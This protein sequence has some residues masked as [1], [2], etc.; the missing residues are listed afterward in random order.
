MAATFVGHPVLEECE[1]RDGEW[2]AAAAPAS[3]DSASVDDGSAS[4]LLCVLLGS[5]AQ[6]V[7][8]HTPLFGATQSLR[9]DRV[10]MC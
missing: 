8:R 9:D 6:E 10:A 2:R 1:W 3:R 4:P 7:A 5:R